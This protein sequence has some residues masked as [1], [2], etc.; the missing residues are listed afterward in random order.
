MKKITLFKSISLYTLLLFSFFVLLFILVN[1]YIDFQTYREEVIN[2]KKI[3]AK[4]VKKTLKWEVE[5]Y[6]EL[7]NNSRKNITNIRKNMLRNRANIAC[8][9]V[10]AI[11]E[12]YKDSK[13]K[14][15]IQK[16]ITTALRKIRFGKN[17]YY[18]I[19]T[20]DG[21]EILSDPQK[22]LEG[23]NILPLQ[24]S[25]G[26]YIIKEMVEFVKKEQEGFF[27][28]MWP[29]PE[30]RSVDKSKIA[31]IKLFEPYNW[32]IGIGAYEEDMISHIQNE[33]LTNIEQMK[34]DMEDENYIFMG[35]WDGT[36][37]SYPAKGKNMYNIQDKNGLFIVQELIK[38]AQNDGGFVRYVMPSFKN[39]RNTEKISYVKGIPEWKWY[40]GAGLY[41]DDINQEIE[42]L[43]EK[44]YEKLVKTSIGTVVLSLLVFLAF[45]YIYK[46]IS[47]RAQEDFSIFINFFN[48]LVYDSKKIDI[49]S[50]RY[51]EFSNMAMHANKMLED[52]IS[53]EDELEKYKKIVSTSGDFLS[54]VDVNYVYQAVN[55]TYLK[56]FNKKREEVVGHS[57]AELFGEEIF[58]EK[59][60]PLTDRAISG[61]A[62]TIEFWMDFPRGRKY[63]ETKYFPYKK[64]GEVI[65]FV[66][67]ARDSTDRKLAEDKV[68]LW[69]KVFDSTSE[70]VMLCD[71]QT[72]ILDVNNAFTDITGFSAKDAIG[73]KSSMISYGLHS[74]LGELNSLCHKVE[75][76]G[77]WSG[78]LKNRRKDGDVY[79]A[80]FS[81]NSVLNEDGKVTNFVAVFTDITT[82]KQSQE[83][84]KY[85]AHHD[86][87]TN[88]PN[89]VLLKDRISHA[90]E[91]AK[92]NE[93]MLAVCFID[94]DNFKKVNDSYG[95]TYGDDI[96][97]QT[98]I[99][100]KSDLREADTLSRIGGD[101]FIL[102]LEN[103][104]DTPEIEAI[105]DK[106]Q[107][108]FEKEFVSNEKNFT[109][110]SSIG[111]S[112]FPQHGDNA[113]DLIKNAD[114]A[115]YKAKDAGKNTYRFF[116][117]EM[118]A[119][120][121]E[122]IDIENDLRTAINEE[123]FVPYYQPQMNL[124]TG[125][126]VG[127]E[128]LVRW[129]H[130][131]KGILSPLQFIKASEENKMIIKIGE[132][133]LRKSCT[134]LKVLQAK[135][136]YPFRV[137]VNLSGVQ[138]E[139]SDFFLVLKRI[140]EETQIQTS[141]LEL[142]I[143]ESVIMKNPQQW[144]DLLNAIKGLGVK[145]SIDDFGTGYS[146]LSYLRK[147]PIDKLKIDM[148][149][150]KDIPKEDDA[151]AIA[152]S[153]ITLSQ[154]MKMITLAEG[155]ETK[156][157]E[158]YLKE[159]NC[160]EGQG[161]LFAKPMDFSSLE[162]WLDQQ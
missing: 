85:L 30:E 61:E 105:L 138:I 122:M 24:N 28:Y 131:Q 82:I 152:N 129:V 76:L 89:R 67:A 14:E 118:S 121:Y 155:I 119:A 42:S 145:V 100:I 148:S 11:Y 161:Y 114:I 32:I 33:I 19:R 127:F 63:L 146:S 144:I 47:R 74:E 71:K 142:E 108:G 83:K 27:K 90:I 125:K 35:Q 65:Y 45:I 40:V 12:Q 56:Y 22:E 160:E 66:V 34:F 115:M 77:A 92:R 5:H 21:T 143:T 153:I 107:I 55:D 79:P 72:N 49:K 95:H 73:N 25:K 94:L 139:H 101:E 60:K 141:C 69:K 136:N 150:V 84:L 23:T 62:F 8:N 88:L 41:I 96:L 10:N 70:A 87:L 36:A 7:I 151:C 29:K 81:A 124:Q 20:V 135:Y 156:E 78:E 64:N 46:N 4:R 154:N 140:I 134:D 157:Q 99:R 110:S 3:H 39:E 86:T 37:L 2:L 109:L 132:Y 13:S 58:N 123:Q 59:I 16:I 159:N 133:M 130:P 31:Y 149:F 147:L 50:I 98:A 52:K 116:N 6:I 97:K 113:E 54:L 102:L 112:L 38:K 1:Y 117:T 104:K 53:L 57:A 80:L 51:D 43:E 137:S 128:A 26:T 120:T 103:L 162:K 75:N 111:I 126:V 44:L 48:S 15:E 106:I 9:I 93:T 158:K 91:N 17:G 18:F 68:K